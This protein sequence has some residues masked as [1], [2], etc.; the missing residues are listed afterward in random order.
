MTVKVISIQ[1]LEENSDKYVEM[2]QEQ[3]ILI[4]VNGRV[5]AKLTACTE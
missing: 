3:D 5:I 2:A 4:M 1:E